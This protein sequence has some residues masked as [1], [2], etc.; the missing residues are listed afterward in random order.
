[1]AAKLYSVD[2]TLEKHYV[3]LGEVVST[4]S[5]KALIR[6]SYAGND[7]YLPIGALEM[8]EFFKTTPTILEWSAWIQK[9]EDFEFLFDLTMELEDIGLTAVFDKRDFVDTQT[10]KN[11]YLSVE[12]DALETLKLVSGPLGLVQENAILSNQDANAFMDALIK[13][14]RKNSARVSYLLASQAK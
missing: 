14:L 12:S 5:L 4:P 3:F 13:L 2:D 10:A 11:L 1:M 8:I 9:K 7:V 6:V